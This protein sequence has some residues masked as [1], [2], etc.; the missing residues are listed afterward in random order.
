[1]GKW[2]LA[3]NLLSVDWARRNGAQINKKGQAVPGASAVLAH[4]PRPQGFD[5]FFVGERD[6]YY[7]NYD[8]RGEPLRAA[9]EWRK[10][11]GYRLD[12]QT[13]AAL[14]FIRRNRSRP[15]FLFLNYF[16]PHVPLVAPPKYLDRFPG[17]MPERRRHALAMISAMDDGV[18]RIMRLL[19]ETGVEENTLVVF[20]SDNGAPLRL[21]MP[22]ERPIDSFD[23]SWD[24]SLNTPWV[25]EKGMLSE[26]GVRVPMVWRWKGVLPAGMTYDQPV[27]ALDIASTAVAA[28]GLPASEELDGVDI[29]PFL[30][31]Q[32]A[33]PPHDLL[34]WRFW[35]QAAVRSGK[36]K[37][38][39]AGG[40]YEFLFDLE[41]PEHELR[42]LIEEHPETAQRLRAALGTWTADLRPAGIP[43]QPLNDQEARW[44][45]HY[46]G[47]ATPD[48]P[49]ARGGLPGNGGA[50]RR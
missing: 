15:F 38:L 29:V 42:N 13:D 22:D 18:G 36:W 37:Y 39:R 31:G 26:G 19:R 27:T 10:E 4:Y 9:G 43:Q 35:S 28:A 17:E 20:T 25:G 24:G 44:Y 34:Y 2:H 47:A 48:A 50:R 11:A 41:S 7:A 14:A 40:A 45:R 6:R 49:T 16:A 12:I 32:Q 1:V 5:D 30:T 46:F 33:G 8:L 3:P 23:G 21:T